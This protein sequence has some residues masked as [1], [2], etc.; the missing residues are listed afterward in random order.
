VKEWQQQP[1]IEG[2]N[3][4][5]R[6]SKLSDSGVHYLKMLSD[7]NPSAPLAEITRDSD[8]DVSEDTVGRALREKG[9]YVYVARE[10]PFLTKRKKSIRHTWC[11]LRQKWDVE[12]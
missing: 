10:K 3:R 6:P 8:P 4:S 9:Y 12:M 5:G 1:D 2:T 11:K 7:K